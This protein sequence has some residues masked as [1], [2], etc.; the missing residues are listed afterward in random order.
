MMA[1]KKVGNLTGNAPEVIAAIVVLFIYCMVISGVLFALPEKGLN[2][3]T[4]ATEKINVLTQPATVDADPE[5]A[6]LELEAI[7]KKNKKC[8][9]CHRRDKVKVLESG[10]EM[11]LQV[12]KEDYA[13]SAHGEVACVSCH[14][15][16][17]SRKHP[18]K[19][20]NITINSRREYSVE[21][22]ESCRNCHERKYTQYE[23]SIHSS[24]VAQGSSKAPLCTDCHSAH[25]VETMSV[26]Q[27]ET[28]L[29]CKKCHDDIFTAYTASVHGSARL[30]GNEIRD[31][32]IQAPI[33]SD[34]HNSHGV[35]AVEIG[36]TLSTQCFG[37]HENVPLLHNQWLPNAGKHLDVVSCAVCHAPFAKHRFDL[38]FFD[39]T[40]QAPVGQQESYEVFQQQLKAL[41]ED[42]GTVDP[43]AVWKLIE[44]GNKNVP[45]NISLRGRLEVKSGIWAHQIAPKSFAVRTCDSCHLPGHR[46]RMGV[47]VS[48][49]QS[50]GTIKS[51][52]ADREELS[53]VGAVDSISDFFAL[54]GN[55]NKLLDIMVLLS[56]ISGIAIPV[57]H[58]TL[59]RMIR[60]KMEIGGLK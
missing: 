32:H 59:G 42:G 39:N 33:C 21:L 16:I 25:S 57:G 30:T 43:L 48:M 12:H 58:F 45:A 19:S 40:V 44:E 11:S 3:T 15:S 13:G 53:S 14:I 26:Y 52:E 60:E 31:E 9:T 6:A 56:F 24:L 18:S 20:T 17:G 38:H 4:V 51:F 22:N 28:G 35:A 8:L 10:E 34:C 23:G 29:P 54:G 47:T 2:T 49:P 55:K 1:R 5:E 46:E 7:L 36:D 41:E 27:P 37:C 50:G